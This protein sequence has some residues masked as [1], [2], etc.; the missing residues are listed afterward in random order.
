[1]EKAPQLVKLSGSARYAALREQLIAN[2][3]LA[4]RVRD[5]R[6]HLSELELQS[7]WFAGAFGNRF[8]TVDGEPV[9]IIQFGHWNHAAGPDFTDT[10]I[11]LRGE[12]R[13]GPIE[14]DPHVRDWERHGHDENAA[15][16]RVVLHVYFEEGP[17][18]FFTRTSHHHEVPQVRLDLHAYPDLEPL[19][20]L[21]A[22]AHLGRCSYIFTEL[23]DS[24]VEEILE[25]AA[26]YRLECKA[27]RLARVADLHGED[28]ALFQGMAE[29]LGYR[30]NRFPMRVLS[31]RAPLTTL[32]KRETPEAID[33]LLFGLAGFL[34]G[35]RHVESPHTDTTAYQ[36][37]LWSLWWHER[38]AWS[39]ATRIPLP[40]KTAGA[41]P[42]NHPQRRLGA[43][44]HLAH[45]WQDFSKLAL[46]LDPDIKRVEA[47][48]TQLR[49]PFWD[50]H[51]T[52]RAASARR[53][54][55]IGPSRARDA[56]ANQVLPLAYRKD[57]E[58]AW[59]RFRQLRASQSNDKLR[60]AAI[61]L[62][63]EHPRQDRFLKKVYHQQA[64]LQIYDDFCL[65]DASAC[66]ACPFPEQLWHLTADHRQ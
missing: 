27:Q 28:Q 18:R 53:L 60:R 63:G 66:E 12:T 16:D 6:S 10:A 40:W 22:D 42:Q 23:D 26:Q 45:A 44:T 33:A 17:E 1:M 50:Q 61:R 51:Y 49:H 3:T 31:Q 11:R 54:A 34:E 56:V 41:R 15:Y 65:A 59:L 24:L 38:D 52:L 30:H 58:A 13:R 25:G 20:Y 46:R 9:E 39:S 5:E 37:A 19:S 57:A 47:F 2:D 14:L 64:L 35:E 32:Q 55:L 62:F 48:L 4:S 7:L 43:L 36:R 8:A 21:P 29:C